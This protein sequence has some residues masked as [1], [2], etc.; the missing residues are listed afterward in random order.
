MSEF[1]FGD[2]FQRLTDNPPFPWQSRLYAQ[3]I[4]GTV[5]SACSIPT[6]L[7]KT[8]VIPIWLIALVSCPE[9]LPRRLVYVVNRRTVVDQSTQVTEEMR[10][11]LLDP[12]GDATLI[13][14]ASRLKRLT[15]FSENEKHPS[16]AISTLRGQFADNG[17]W[18]QDP[19]RPAVVVGTVDM[20]GSRLLFGGYRSGVRSHPRDAGFLGRDVLIVHHKAH[21]KP[22]FQFLL[23]A[24][25]REQEKTESPSRPIHILELTAT[26]RAQSED[27]PFT[28]DEKDHEHD[29]V[30]QRTHAKKGIAFH[31]VET[32]AESIGV[33]A[34]EYAES[35]KAILIFVRTLK[36]VSTVHEKL[37]ETGAKTALLT[38]TIRGF[39]RE[40]LAISDPVYQR[41]L[42]PSEEE[43]QETMYLIC[44]SAGE[45]GID[46]SADHLVCDLTP[47]ESMAQRFGRV[48]RRGG[49]H[50]ANLDIF[51]EQ[52]HD[53]RK[54]ELGYEIARW[55]TLD[56]L[57]SL[58][59]CDWDDQR[60]NASPQALND[61]PHDAKCEAFSP[62]PEILCT[63]DIL[64]DAWTM[65]SIREDLPGRPPV[66]DYLH[67]VEEN[68][69]P[70]TMVAWREEV[71]LLVDSELSDEH[72]AELLSD[73]PLKPQ[74]LLRE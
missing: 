20:I 52:E 48:N 18:W 50:W 35:G 33:R 4:E 51:Y 10:A 58:P 3:F 32:V 24:I 9:R 63:S 70:E 62:L 46:I 59:P 42:N 1:S 17:E 66:A 21:L 15:S 43:S 7:G 31:E 28:L 36:D 74:E 72:L 57:Q 8:S 26:S 37:K 69:I 13:D 61:L 34:A 73:Y 67:G 16:L 14:L 71:S 45:V 25:D 30:Q 38:G 22:A 19:A 41:F 6:G 29:V 64:F 11:R 44:T 55:K 49:K 54:A 47:F 12:K 60:R 53:S 56:L 65:T 23:K 27:A 2:V 39:E 5:P 68:Q 40:N